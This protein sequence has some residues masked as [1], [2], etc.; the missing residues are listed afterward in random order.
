[1]ALV[2]LGDCGAERKEKKNNDLQ[3]KQEH[4]AAIVRAFHPHLG[5][6]SRSSIKHSRSPALP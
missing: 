3:E 6:H 4:H 1:M 5:F 2:I